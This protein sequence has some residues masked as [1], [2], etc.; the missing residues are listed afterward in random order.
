MD[1]NKSF[2]QFAFPPLLVM[3]LVLLLTVIVQ[4]VLLHLQTQQSWTGLRLMPDTPSGF[5]RVDAVIADSP[6]SGKFQVGDIITA[7]QIGDETFPLASLNVIDLK[8]LGT[9]QAYNR[10]MQI[11]AQL[12]Q[13][14]QEQ[15]SIDFVTAAGEKITVLPAENMP[16]RALPARHWWLLM[17]NALGVPIG[18]FVW[19]ARPQ[20]LEGRL[21]LIAGFAHYC[22]LSIY[23]LFAGRD[24]FMDANLLRELISLQATAMHVFVFCIFTIQ[25]SYPRRLLPV[26]GIIVLAL[27]QMVLLFNYRWQWI[28]L[29]SHIFF[30]QF[31]PLFVVSI[32]FSGLQWVNAKGKP[33]NRAAILVSQIAVLLPSA[34]MILLY[35]VPV[36]MG[37]PPF[38]ESVAAH[39]MP[40]FIFLGWAIA[41][42][43]YRLFEI[44]YWWFKITLWLLGGFLV[45]LVD[46]AVL[47]LF[48]VSPF[49]SLGFSVIIAG[50][51]YF[52]LRQWLLGKL[53]PLDSQSVQDFLPTFSALMGSAVSRE[54]FGQRW[55]AALST[56]FQP[57]NITV[58]TQPLSAATL[59]EN[60]L[61][62]DVPNLYGDASL[63]LTGKQQGMRL[64]GRADLKT[65]TSL[66]EIARIASNASDTRQQA[67]LTE[68]TRIMR[69]LHDTVGAKLLT[70][71]HTLPTPRHRQAAQ[72]SLQILRDIINLTLH[73]SPFLLGE[74]L[75]DWRA[76]TVDRA[77]AAGVQ[78]HWQVDPTL[79]RLQ[80]RPGQVM[81]LLV[82]VRETMTCLLQSP[83]VTQ[84]DVRC[85]REGEKLTL[86][87]K[88]AEYPPLIIAH[89]L[90][91]T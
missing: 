16:L 91:F 83:A 55:Q 46:V 2:K 1:S 29:P 66:L 76:E 42:L 61:H 45:V 62:L 6:A 39:F 71:S 67:V 73:K 88:S 36:I 11:Q 60:G 34:L 38:L 15:P 5:L 4:V 9:H 53:M 32:V 59:A 75:A 70:L 44:E 90:N 56:R 74:Y 43:R 12:Q 87:F 20:S 84:L 72:E 40:L 10:F 77:E 82:F 69:D 49:Y 26:K 64:F 89:S 22:H 37:T 47:M 86:C 54:E 28:E 79:E 63:R 68:R 78:L 17:V 3:L 19:L 80:L 21:L 57:L 25:A 48:N 24:L 50:F 30:L 8:E 33:I 18:F 65:V 52:P 27:L 35:A 7:L 81:E 41:I 51:L 14:I 13:L 85:D 31:I 58:Q 23:S